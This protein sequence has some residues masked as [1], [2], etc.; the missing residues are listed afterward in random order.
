MDGNRGGTECRVAGNPQ[1]DVEAGPTQST[2][3]GADS[4]P[5]WGLSTASA[6]GSLRLSQGPTTRKCGWRGQWRPEWL[7]VPGLH[8]VTGGAGPFKP[9]RA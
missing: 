4:G 5:Q 6:G 3:R 9:C 7:S 8:W 2:S 1:A